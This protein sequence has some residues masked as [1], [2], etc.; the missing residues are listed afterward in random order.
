VPSPYSVRPF[1]VLHYLTLPRLEATLRVRL[2]FTGRLDAAALR[3]AFT[4][5]VQTVPVIAAS[6][7]TNFLRA[8]WRPHPEQAQEICAA[9]AADS[10]AAAAAAVTTAWEAGIDVTTGPNAQA[11]LVQGPAGDT[12]VVR[13]SHLVGDVAAFRAW[14][15]E[16][17]R[18]YT[19]LVAGQPAVPAPFKTR[20]VSPA[21]RSL[22]FGRRFRLF[23]SMPSSKGRVRTAGLE[24]PDGPGR[25]VVVRVPAPAFAAAHE[26]A[27]A[28]GVTVNALLVAACGRAECRR[29]GMDR[30][31]FPFTVDLRPLVPAGQKY[32]ITNL[33]ANAWA[34][35]TPGA[36]TLAD[37]ARA[38]AE[39][40]ADVPRRDELWA[41]TDFLRVATKYIPYA[42]FYAVYGRNAKIQPLILTNWGVWPEADVRFGEAPARLTGAAGFK[43]SP[44]LQVNACTF[45]GELTLTA[46]V[47]TDDAGAAA[48]QGLLADMAAEIKALGRGPA[49][50][51]G[52]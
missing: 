34:S 7:H 10:P 17:A 47:K 37:T 39:A 52:A 49:V 13:F 4:L 28:D 24:R 43:P 32:G 38:V 25:S 5:S 48:V 40:T 11:T 33:T 6:F 30:V 9:V 50:A 31:D 22:P 27:R 2:E 14:L 18:L 44:T 1:D 29:T 41:G 15:A 45:R 42:F 35:V 16:V 3:Q 20:A 26:R 23:F 36:G 46:S 8:H 19:A 12:L 51:A 21:L